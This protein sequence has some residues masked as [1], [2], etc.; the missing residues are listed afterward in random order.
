MKNGIF[1]YEFTGKYEKNEIKKLVPGLKIINHWYD[2]YGIVKSNLNNIPPP[3][4]R[5]LGRFATWDHRVK[6]QEVIKQSITQFD[7]VSVWNKQ[8]DF[9]LNFFDFNVQDIDKQQVLTKDFALRLTDEV[10]ELLSKINWKTEEYKTVQIDKSQIL[11]EW[12]DVFKYWLGIGNVWGFSIE[13]FFTEF[14][15]KSKIIDNRYKKFIKPK[16]QA[17]AT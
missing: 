4:V 9:N 5:F 6:I 17:D 12:I 13:D 2:H 8:K 1:L 15:R 11:E 7:F 3:K 16:K 14:W 10:H